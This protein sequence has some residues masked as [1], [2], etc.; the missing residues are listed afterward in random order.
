MFR[1]GHTAFHAHADARFRGFGLAKQLLEEGHGILDEK[2]SDKVCP[3]PVTI[4]L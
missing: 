2:T 4:T 1:D 3:Y